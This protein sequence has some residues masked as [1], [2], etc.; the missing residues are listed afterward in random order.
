M[1]AHVAHFILFKNIPDPGWI[2]PESGIS[3]C[4]YLVCT[5]CVEVPGQLQKLAWDLSSK[6]FETPPG[7]PSNPTGGGAE[8]SPHHIS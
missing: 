2:I 3:I 1:I 4:T 7:A 8:N 5:C 6:G